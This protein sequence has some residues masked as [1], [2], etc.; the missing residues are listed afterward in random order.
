[1]CWESDGGSETEVVHDVRCVG[2]FVVYCPGKLNAKKNALSAHK[3]LF[4]TGLET[5]NGPVYERF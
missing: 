2:V 1:M 4:T 3:T 5:N